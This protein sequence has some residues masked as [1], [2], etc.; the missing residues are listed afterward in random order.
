[1]V[2]FEVCPCLLS[3]IPLAV[4]CVVLGVA[5]FLV[6]FLT[7]PTRTPVHALHPNP[8]QGVPL[9]LH[10]LL[11]IIFA[12]LVSTSKWL[13][14][15]TLPYYRWIDLHAPPQAHPT[16]RNNPRKR[17]SFVFFSPNF[18]SIFQ[19]EVRR[20]AWTGRRALS[21]RSS[22]ARAATNASKARL[23]RF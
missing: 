15:T 16:L 12:S 3:P 2:R 14:G 13:G 17:G 18:W 10:A 7:F 1:M 22:D 6:M 19:S 9:V 20:V 5:L 11:Y 23:K 8:M 21:S 4:P